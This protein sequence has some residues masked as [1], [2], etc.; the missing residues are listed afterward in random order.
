MTDSYA[1]DNTSTEQARLS[2]QS[3]RLRPITERRFRAAGMGPGMS[4]LD[5]GCGAGDVSLIT[6]ELVT[7]S[8]RVVGFDRDPRQV[9]AAADRCREFPAVSFIEGSI[10]DPPDGL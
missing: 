2:R 6:A 1:L 5:V 7:G 10:E 8:G 4:V 9:S 3:L